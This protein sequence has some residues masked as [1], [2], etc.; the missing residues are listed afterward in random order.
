MSTQQILADLTH[1]SISL[2]EYDDN[3]NLVCTPA[4]EEVEKLIKAYEK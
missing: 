4:S 1:L 2:M 3:G